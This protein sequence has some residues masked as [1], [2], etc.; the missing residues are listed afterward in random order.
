[1]SS[2]IVTVAERKAREAA[3]RRAAASLI[4]AELKTFAVERG[5]RFLIFGSAA[6]DK[7]K[8]D[9]DLDVVID[10]P[11]ELEAEALDFVEDACRRQNLPVEIF[12]KS[13]SSSR[14]LNRIRDHMMQVP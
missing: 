1:M 11:A 3:R 7:M 10:F 13:R 14:F 8:F 4:M 6:E 12:L 5:G 2:S 9:S